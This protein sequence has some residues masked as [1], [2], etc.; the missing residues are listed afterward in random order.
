MK[1][2]EFTIKEIAEKSGVSEKQLLG[3]LNADEKI[4]D[5]YITNLLASYH[6]VVEHIHYTDIVDDEH[7]FEE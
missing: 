6:I 5:H 4:P 7:E 2:R 1:G 3:F